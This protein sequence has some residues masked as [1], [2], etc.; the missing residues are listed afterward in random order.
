MGK[1]VGPGAVADPNHDNAGGDVDCDL[2][3]TTG[4]RFEN[5]GG[6]LRGDLDWAALGSRDWVLLVVDG[7]TGRI[8]IAR[9]AD[10]RDRAEVTGL[11]SPPF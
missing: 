10:T 8:F 6:A 2:W 4:P 9:I 1:Y 3:S 7:H 5:W 11:G